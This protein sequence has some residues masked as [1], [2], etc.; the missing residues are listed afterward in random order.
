MANSFFRLATALD[1][2]AAS[3]GSKSVSRAAIGEAATDTF[4]PSSE[5]SRRTFMRYST[6]NDRWLIIG[7]LSDF[8]FLYGNI[9]CGQASQLSNC[10]NPYLNQAAPQ[11]SQLI[12]KCPTSA[13][14]NLDSW[15]VEFRHLVTAATP[16]LRL[17]VA[18]AWEARMFFAIVVSVF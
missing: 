1:N 15:V 2:T 8:S 13:S 18:L 5:L 14:S 7:E 17:D 4:S 3:A 6:D 10:P 11:S 16:I 12:L 9:C